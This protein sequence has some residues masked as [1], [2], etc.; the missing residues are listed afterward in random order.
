MHWFSYYKK[1]IPQENYYYAFK[2]T[3]FKPN[4]LGRSAGTYTKYTSLDDMMDDFNFFCM[5]IKYGIGRATFDA[6]QEIRRGDITREE[7]AAL[8]KKYDGEFPYRF[9][10]KIFDYLS[11][12]QIPNYG[13][14][15][16][17][18]FNNP[19]M[20][21]NSFNMLCDRFR[22]PHL[23]EKDSNNKWKLKYEFD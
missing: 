7:G 22:S 16:S 23:W 3:G 1:W 9:Q 8:V 14:N 6:A 11:I 2:N 17:K 10:N 4:P 12:N 18:K 19:G 13:D 15:W 5:Y 21:M 20:D